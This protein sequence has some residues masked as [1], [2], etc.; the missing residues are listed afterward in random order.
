MK[1][2]LEINKDT[3]NLLAPE[4]NQRWQKYLLHQEDVLKPFFVNLK[5]RFNS[6]INVLDIGCGVGL[7]SFILNNQGFTVEG[8]D[9]SEKMIDF[10]RQNVINGKFA[11][12]DFTQIPAR[13][14][15]GLLMDAFI[16]LFPKN[17]IPSLLEK[18]KSCLLPGGLA[19]ICT[20]KSETSS[21]GFLEKADYH[22][23]TL[24]F[25]KH[26]TQEEL[27]ETLKNSGFKIVEFYLD[28][29]TTYNKVWMNVIIETDSK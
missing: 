10:A 9:I 27:I 7:D 25:R 24:R 3:F 6:N 22:I 4:Y 28:H 26:W 29:E 5:Q 2:Y 19:F 15:N 18:I 20:T 14:F 12:G 11:V 13:R 23:K 16:H 8:V 17:E 21:E 1:D